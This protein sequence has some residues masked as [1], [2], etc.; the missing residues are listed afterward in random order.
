MPCHITSC[1]FLPCHI[2]LSHITSRH[3]MPCHVMSC[4]ITS[5][6]AMSCHVMLYHITSCHAMSHHVMPCHVMSCIKS[7]H[8]ILIFSYIPVD[9]HTHLEGGGYIDLDVVLLHDQPHYCIEHLKSHANFILP[10]HPVLSREINCYYF[11]K[12]IKKVRDFLPSRQVGN[13]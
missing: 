13:T 3:V 5:R 1:H 10:E 4:Y 12:K 11:F 2:T 9:V 6:H 7:C 8:V